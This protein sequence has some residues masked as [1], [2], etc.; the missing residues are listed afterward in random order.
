MAINDKKLIIRGE[1]VLFGTS[2][3]CSPE[4]SESTT[5]TFS[6]NIVEGLEDVPWE[7][8]AEKVEYDEATDSLRLS[9]IIEH[10][11]KNKEMV[12]V[13]EIKRPTG[14]DPYEIVDDF[15][16]C[17]VT[18]NDYEI[19]VDDHTVNKLKIKAERRERNYYTLDGTLITVEDF[20]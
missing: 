20:L 12:T 13:R 6:G 9:L 19:K 5:K 17:I 1:S 2:I 18:G 8:E 11:L 14:S 16:G 10:M 15:F 3:K 4:T 7:I